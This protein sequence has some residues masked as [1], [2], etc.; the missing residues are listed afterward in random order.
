MLRQKKHHWERRI[1]LLGT[2]V[3]YYL[4]VLVPA[5]SLQKQSVYI[6]AILRFFS[7]VL[8]F[9]IK[10]FKFEGKFIDSDNMF[11]GIIL[12]GS[13]KESLRE[14]ESYVKGKNT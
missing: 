14:E 13:C 1:K 2:W 7:D 8:G 12:K 6:A 4:A 9:K 11:S 5:S 3:S 10:V